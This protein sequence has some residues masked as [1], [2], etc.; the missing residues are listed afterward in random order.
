M[1]PAQRADRADRG[2]SVFGRF[3]STRD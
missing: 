1:T 2:E 3:P